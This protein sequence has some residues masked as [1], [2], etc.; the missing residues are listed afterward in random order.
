MS[1]NVTCP[2]CGKQAQWFGCGGCGDDLG[3]LACASCGATIPGM[4]LS[5]MVRSAASE[6]A[7]R[8][9]RCDVQGQNDSRASSR[10]S[11][12]EWT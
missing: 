10:R 7:Q 2:V 4:S 12:S 8:V 3:T 1:V 5:E 6:P 11:S 9:E